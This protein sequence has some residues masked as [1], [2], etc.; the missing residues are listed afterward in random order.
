M[1]RYSIKVSVFQ[2]LESRFGFL[3]NSKHLADTV[4]YTKCDA[5]EFDVGHKLFDL[6]LSYTSNHW[7]NCLESMVI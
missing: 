7:V 2:I 6:I 3:A 1:S 5:E 4:V